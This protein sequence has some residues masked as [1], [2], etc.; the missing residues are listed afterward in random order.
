[1]H[2][3]RASALGASFAGH[4]VF[5][6]AVLVLMRQSARAP[7]STAA[8]PD[9]AMPRMVWLN[10][11]GPGGG[12]GGGGNEM[13]DPPRPAERMGHDAMT[14]PAAKP[15]APD[16]SKPAT[17]DP[18]A[19]PALVIPVA[20]LASA[21]EALPQIGAVGAPPSPTLSQ[22][23]GEEEGAGTGKGTGDGPGRG[24]GFGPGQDRNTGGGPVGP[25][26]GVTMPVEIQKGIPRYTSEAMRARVQGA[27][28]VECVVQTSGVCTDIRV[29][30]SFDPA[31]GLDQEAI[32]AAAQWRF[33]PGT[34]RGEA[35][36]VMVTMEIAFA[37]R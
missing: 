1:M 36:P 21:T 24:R 37:L 16:F 25:G 4:V 27:I 22:G 11:P 17:T 7:G 8:E 28:V 35:V 12:G 9:R 15:P 18:P 2:P 13:K 19:L 3:R 20:N 10:A 34:L 23:P 29:K 14:V 6:A 26:N 33:R 5:L 30:R 32:K 31:F